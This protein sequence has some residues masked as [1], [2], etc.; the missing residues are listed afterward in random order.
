MN[1]LPN[2]ST[3]IGANYSKFGPEDNEVLWQE[4]RPILAIYR[5]LYVYVLA[6]EICLGS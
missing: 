4:I 6:P 2:F 1:S 3:C 5:E